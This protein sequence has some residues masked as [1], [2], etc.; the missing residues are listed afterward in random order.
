MAPTG[1]AYQVDWVVSNNSNVHVAN[2]RDWFTE[3]TPF[4][5][6]TGSIYFNDHSS[7]VAGVGTVEL[8]LKLYNNKRKGRPGYRTIT[9]K[10]VLYMPS[11][12]C[13]IFGIPPSPDYRLERL[14]GNGGT[15]IDR[16][17]KRAGLIEVV[18]LFRLRLHGQRGGV[19][20]L[21]DGMYMINTHWP[22]NERARWEAAKPYTAE[23]KEW[24][25][26]N[27]E[28]EFKFLNA[29]GLSVHKE[30]DREEGRGMVRKFMKEGREN[31]GDAHEDNPEYEL[32][33]RRDEEDEEDPEDDD[34]DDFLAELERDP[35]SHLADRHFSEA[36]LA[37]IKKHYRYSSKF[38]L[39]HGLKPYDDGD[40]VMA[41]TLLQGL[42]G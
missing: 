20:S 19:S 39:S 7:Q 22:N 13:N 11:A 33:F 23:E 1:E 42:M 31:D 29:Y 8:T 40:C 3:Y 25:K 5:T 12:V 41:A 26:K 28:G 27:W 10:D 30:E 17:G 9:L 2:N 32:E 16:D 18:R 35:M 21:G 38:M 24:L 36:Q 34:S 14:G 4:K 37:W 6:H 15:I